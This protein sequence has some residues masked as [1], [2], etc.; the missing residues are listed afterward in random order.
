[1][2]TLGVG[3]CRAV[4]NSSKPVIV[5]RQAIK[6]RTIAIIFGKNL[7]SIAMFVNGILE[8]CETMMIATNKKNPA[9]NN[10]LYFSNINIPP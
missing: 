8:S 3:V 5:K 7:E 4:F 9:E 6:K 1:M 2:S 10:L